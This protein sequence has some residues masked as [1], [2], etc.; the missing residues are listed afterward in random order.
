MA[1]KIKYKNSSLPR[2][3]ATPQG[4]AIGDMQTNSPGGTNMPSVGKMVS[5]KGLMNYGNVAFGNRQP[6]ASAP[7]NVPSG[8]GT[9]IPY[10]S[11]INSTIIQNPSAIPVTTFY[12]VMVS[13]PIVY[14]S[15]LYMIT[16]IISRIGDYKNS[17]KE[18]EKI[19]CDAI[20]RVGKMKLCQSLLTSLWA[21]FAAIKLVWDYIDGYTTIKN[22]LVLPPDSIMLAVTPEGE[23]DPDFGVMQ[24]YYNLN[25]EWNQ[26]QKAFSNFGNA[27]F[28]AFS[29]YMSPQRQVSFNPMFLSAFPKNGRI[30]HT[31]NPIGLEGNFWGTSMIQSIFSNVVDKNNLKFKLQVGATYKAA[32][33]V[34]AQTDTQTMVETASGDYI[35]KAQDF[36]QVM[37]EGAETGFLISEG[38]DAVKFT[39]LDNTAKL[40]EMIMAI[41]NCNHEIRAGLVTPD[42]VGNSGSYANAMANNQANNEIINNITEHV[43]NTLIN[44]F[45]K[46]ILEEAVG[47]EEDFGYFELLDNSLNDRAIWAKILESTKSL[48]IIDPKDID[49]VNFMRKKMGL[50]PVDKLSDDIIYGMMGLLEAGNMD[51][52]SNIT[53]MK[54]DIKAPYSGGLDKV[55]KNHYGKEAS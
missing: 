54:E 33:M 32:P 47:E 10:N 50:Q 23:L 40:D 16:S 14:S 18:N 3:T 26:N 7:L 8:F 31:F 15:M 41:Q 51:L 22:I 39:T 25:S 19:V 48:G 5:Y 21:G 2:N 9:Q 42:L 13:D 1:K 36:Q 43:I 45:A 37:S 55:Q 38:M 29:G 4:L 11:A 28:A 6:N 17:N 35:S 52:G 27:P 46:V 49:D 44:Q 12:Q 20:K 24:Y 53:K 34:V 30:L